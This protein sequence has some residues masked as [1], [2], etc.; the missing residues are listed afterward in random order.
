MKTK[1]AY[2]LLALTLIA[3]P[4]F[5]AAASAHGGRDLSGHSRWD[6]WGHHDRRHHGHDWS[7]HGHHE[8]RHGKGYREP[9]VVYRDRPVRYRSGWDGLTIIY[10]GRLR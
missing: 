5:P 9:R 3:A 1:P 10:N 7:R 6:Q 4:L 8:S 2:L